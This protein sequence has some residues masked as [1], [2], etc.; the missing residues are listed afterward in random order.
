M[1]QPYSK[2]ALDPR[3]IFPF[4]WEKNED[5]SENLSTKEIWENF[6]RAKEEQGLQ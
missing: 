2:H 1:L 4:P 5:G 3:A 6:N